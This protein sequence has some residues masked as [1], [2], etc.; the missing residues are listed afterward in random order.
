MS[1]KPGVPNHDWAAAYSEL[2]HHVAQLLSHEW[3]P[4]GFSPPSK[5]GHQATCSQCS[6]SEVMRA[7]AEWD[8]R[9]SL[10]HRGCLRR[11]PDPLLRHRAASVTLKEQET[12]PPKASLLST[13]SFLQ[14]DERLQGSNLVPL[15]AFRPLQKLLAQRSLKECKTAPQKLL[16]SLAWVELCA[17][18]HHSCGPVPLYPPPPTS[19]A[20]KPQ[21]LRTTD[22]N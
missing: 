4:K 13:E 5:P 7:E 11:T 20:A 19:Q 6:K 16:F 10:T 18:T 8:V 9:A 17:L 22:L 3:R 14:T 21:R 12:V 2:A 15:Q 1:P